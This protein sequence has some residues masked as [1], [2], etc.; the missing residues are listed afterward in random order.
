VDLKRT[1]LDPIGA[2]MCHLIVEAAHK[3]R[4]LGSYPVVLDLAHGAELVFYAYYYWDGQWE[5]DEPSPPT[6]GEKA[7]SSNWYN[8]NRGDY[9]RI[10]VSEFMKIHPAD[11][12]RSTITHLVNTHALENDSFG[13]PRKLGS[14]R[15]RRDLELDVEL[16][17]P[18]FPER[19]VDHAAYVLEQ[20]FRGKL[21]EL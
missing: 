8:G 16:C 2:S 12:M 4:L 20:Y 10:R 19:V 14:R 21:Q 18:T 17:D 7:H 11:G 9:N 3:H 15:K 6:Y 13:P 1:Y 5:E